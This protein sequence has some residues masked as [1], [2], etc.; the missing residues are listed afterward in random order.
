MQPVLESNNRGE[1]NI[2]FCNLPES[3]LFTYLQNGGVPLQFCAGTTDSISLSI[4]RLA[5]FTLNAGNQ[6]NIQLSDS[7]GSFAN[8]VLLRT[9]NSQITSGGA[10]PNTTVKVGLPPS[11]L[12]GRGYRL[13]A[14][15]TNPVTISTTCGTDLTIIGNQ[16][17]LLNQNGIL[18]APYGSRFQWLRDGQPVSG[19]IFQT[20]KPESEGSYSCQV[21]QGSCIHVTE[22]FVQT[23]IPDQVSTPEDISLYPNPA[24]GSFNIKTPDQEM[25]AGVKIYDFA[26]QLKSSAEVTNGVSVPIDRLVPGFYLVH[27]QAEGIIYQRKL[28][29]SK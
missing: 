7:N 9:V 14:V 29:V 19:A 8:P 15:S 6:L 12:P 1:Q 4:G 18:S 2:G 13:R 28:V 16:T 21:F 20:Y 27:I 22:A 24:W 11:V 17:E 26:G 23:S 3:S 5:S 25:K 10:N